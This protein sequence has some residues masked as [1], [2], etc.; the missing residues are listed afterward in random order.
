MPQ[1]LSRLSQ[2]GRDILCEAA[3][4]SEMQVERLIYR[5]PNLR[6]DVELDRATS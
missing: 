3:R 2:H 6:R 4:R 1:Y 5:P